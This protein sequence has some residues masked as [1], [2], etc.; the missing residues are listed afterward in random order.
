M[1]FGEG[2]TSL[3]VC[4]GAGGAALGLES[5]GFTHAGLVELDCHACNTLSHNRP[6]WNVLEKDLNRI[7][8][9]EFRGIDLLSGGVPCPPFSIAGKRLGELDERDLFPQI[10]RLTAEAQPRGVLV[11]NVRGLLDPRFK[12]YR[13]C[14]EE[15]FNELG[16]RCSWTI[17]NASNFGVPQLRPRV[18]L[19]ALNPEDAQRFEFPV[20]LLT[21]PPTVGETLRK[22]M[23][24]AGWEGSDLWSTRAN[25]IAPTL[26]GGSKLH[27]GPDLGP[28]R[29]K[30]AWALLGVDAHGVAD[31][32]PGPGFEGMPKLTVA[33][34]ALIQGFPPSW[35]FIGKKTHA[36]RQVGNALPP[37]LAQAVA[38]RIILAMRGSSSNVAA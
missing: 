12:G 36:Y 16:Y 20:P 27:G 21:D 33:M 1:S 18:L 23:A 28:T 2:L 5:A 14:L 15:R 26:V 8:G 6:T 11:E 25:R 37:P 9:R 30:K 10:L 17:L 38:E 31:S 4:A 24:S 34:A 32:P 22:E 7:D 19:V 3:E 35:E 29:S 13:Q